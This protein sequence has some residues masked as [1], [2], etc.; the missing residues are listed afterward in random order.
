MMKNSN[1]SILVGIDM[2]SQTFRAMAA[3]KQPDGTLRVLGVEESSLKRCV[4]HGVV[5]ST[6]DA[7]YMLSNIF[8]LL[9]NRVGMELSP[10][11][12]LCAGGKTMKVVPV[13]SSRDLVHK[14]GVDADLLA[15]M[16][17][18]CRHKIEA[19]NQEVGILDI[20]PTYY[21][22]DG[23]EYEDTPSANQLATFVEAHY[24]AFVG[25]KELSEKIY[26]SFQQATLDLE[27]MYV[28]P[29]ALMNALAHDVMEQ[30]CAVLDLG[31]QTTTLTIYK[32]N[33][34]LYNQV[35]PMGGLDITERIMELGVT[36][37][38]AERL[39]CGYGV[40]AAHMV[41]AKRQYS[42]TGT[43]GEKVT[44]S[45]DQL[46]NTISAQLDE[47]LAPLM[48]ALNKETH[49]LKVLYV[50]GGG[51]MLQGVVE[52]IQSKTPLPTMF[53][54]HAGWLSD[55]TPDEY[56]QPQYASLV[57]TLLLAAE[58]REAHP[59]VKS[60]KK[61]KPIIEEAKNMILDLFSRTDY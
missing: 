6:G 35:V 3:E 34:Y 5:E 48:E 1:S 52:Y 51:A 45:S 41:K 7:G 30:G 15:K 18:E 36:M 37:M 47:M 4:Q 53:G 23:V 57:G 17:A 22:L 61:N 27:K 9:C 28:R 14:R 44:I 55:D 26:K 60:Y 58:Y 29:E 49:P 38:Q 46:A 10:S 40:A 19:K 56:C 21:K 2:G 12:F 24:N 25:R 16:D 59:M 31:A 32:G 42:M 13:C 54:S 39:K 11:V 33:E 50:T 8:R 20:I 43:T